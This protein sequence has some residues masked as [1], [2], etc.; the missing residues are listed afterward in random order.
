MPS[1]EAFERCFISGPIRPVPSQDPVVPAIVADEDI[2]LRRVVCQLVDAG[3][4]PNTNLRG[5]RDGQIPLLHV[6]VH[7]R[8]GT[9]ALR[10]LLKKGANA[11]TRDASGKTV[12]HKH[13]SQRRGHRPSTD[14]PHVS[15]QHDAA[16]EMADE[17][18]ETALHAAAQKGT[19]EQ[20]QL[21]LAACR[22]ADVAV[23]L[24]TLD[25]R[26]LLRYAIAASNWD[27]VKFLKSCG[28]DD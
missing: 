24:G 3:A 12:L 7:G 17:A 23:R 16:P 25:G 21:C 10:G 14:A 22:D 13:F 18:G 9:G 20:L 27:N 6:A 8:N 15:L 28:L 19:L 4:D 11:N 5:V 2:R 26:S 1:Q